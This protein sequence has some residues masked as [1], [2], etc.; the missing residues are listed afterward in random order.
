MKKDW[1]HISLGALLV[2]LIIPFYIAMGFTFPLGDDFARANYA[3]GIFDIG[4]AVEE[5]VHAWTSWSGRYTHHFLIIFL[6]KAAE[7]RLGYTL[8]CAA[9]VSVYW[10]SFYGIFHE[11]FGR[12]RR[13][14]SFLIASVCTLA[15]LS[16][17]PALN[18]SYYLITDVL[19]LGI[20]NGLV[21]SFIWSLCCLWN[22]DCVSKKLKTAVFGTGIAAIGCYEH[23]AIAIFL[24]AA[25]ACTLAYYFSHPHKKVYLQAVKVVTVFFLISFLAMGN[26][27]RQVKRD[28][29][30]AL[31]L[32]QLSES[33]S[34]WKAHAFSVFSSV[35]GLGV[36]F[37]G[38]AIRPASRWCVNT[39]GGFPVPLMGGFVIFLALTGGI[40]IVQAL[41][42]VPVTAT[43]KLTASM[44]LLS[45]YVCCFMAI[46]A[47][48]PLKRKLATVPVSL[49]SIPFIIVFVLTPNYQ[50]LLHE[51]FSGSAVAYAASL[52][53]RYT[54]LKWS[55][56]ENPGGTTKVSRLLLYPYPSSPG[57]AIP[58]SPEEWPVRHVSR[59]FKLGRVISS[60]PDLAQAYA[61]ITTRPPRGEFSTDNST[62]MAVFKDITAGPNDTFRFHW[63][64]ADAS[65]SSADDISTLVLIRRQLDRPVPVFVQRM[66]EKKV[67]TQN[68]ILRAEVLEYAGITN[69]NSLK[70]WSLPGNGRGGY[71]FPVAAPEWGEILAVYASKDGIE[72]RKIPFVE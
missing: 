16:G 19:G 29:T 22:A 27:N 25:L 64:L 2:V 42:D 28:V 45:S 26:F 52:E 69:K 71:L 11:L 59:M 67:L 37:V 21:L 4:K 65:F 31:I 63:L 7:S 5:M 70:N 58:S 57:E 32:E 13:G 14:D 55:G 46:L 41:S 35:W 30:L 61:E 39:S 43:S 9:G 47:M 18:I 66:M 3:R 23:A 72:Y 6:G 17:H 56:L 38:T 8:V 40:V 51:L 68:V 36:L 20:G 54:F 62:G 44:S 15:F 53:K 48:A 33:W 10:L 49:L 50:R 1:P 24:I 12:K 60:P 34:I